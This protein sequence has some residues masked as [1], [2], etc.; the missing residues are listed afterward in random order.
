MEQQKLKL[1]E[2]RPILSVTQ[3]VEGVKSQLEAGFRDIW[4]RGE[5]SNLRKRITLASQQ[6]LN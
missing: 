1:F 6:S 3:I 2:E 5:L 4:V